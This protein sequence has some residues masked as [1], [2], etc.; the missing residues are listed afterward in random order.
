L[1][2][3]VDT[4][5][6][7]KKELEE[8]LEKEKDNCGAQ[9]ARVRSESD[10]AIAQATKSIEN[11]I[12][13]RKMVASRKE[14]EERVKKDLEE[15]KSALIQALSEMAEKAETK[16]SGIKESSTPVESSFQDI[17]VGIFKPDIDDEATA[18]S[19][20]GLAVSCKEADELIRHCTMALLEKG[21]DLQA[22]GATDP[23]KPG[24]LSEIHQA[25]GKLLLHMKELAEIA[26]KVV[27][28]V[29]QGQKLVT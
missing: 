11:I 16:C 27:Q 15:R 24:Q 8:L 14:E 18:E 13:H 20:K 9:F 10:R 1:G 22:L 12:L 25:V 6:G 26:Q 19:V 7:L 5:E 21:P 23:Q 17:T 2:P 29:N 28:I 4:F 3:K